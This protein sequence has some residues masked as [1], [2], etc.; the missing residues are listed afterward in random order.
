MCPVGGKW[1][2]NGLESGGSDRL[3]EGAQVRQ[4]GETGSG[5]SGTV[6]FTSYP[7]R[8]GSGGREVGC[9]G[10]QTRVGYRVDESARVRQDGAMGSG[11]S[12]TAA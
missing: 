11:W 12:V 7:P 8:R 9:E 1:A 6:A 2:A 10:A 4:D 3:D 5:W